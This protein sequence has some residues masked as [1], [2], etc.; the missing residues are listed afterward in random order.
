VGTQHASCANWVQ[1]WG[2]K[3]SCCSAAHWRSVSLGRGHVGLALN[4]SNWMHPWL[5]QCTD[6]HAQDVPAQTLHRC[7][8]FKLRTAQ[9]AEW[10]P[11]WRKCS[12]SSSTGNTVCCNSCWLHNTARLHLTTL[13]ALLPGSRLLISLKAPCTILVILVHYELSSHQAL[14]NASSEMK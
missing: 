1:V 8:H 7:T 2:C 13:T 5:S 11:F 6:W 3:H 10:Q 14:E 9:A 12:S 4:P